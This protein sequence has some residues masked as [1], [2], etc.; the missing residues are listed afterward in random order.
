MTCKI[1]IRNYR[2][3]SLDFFQRRLI[4][5]ASNFIFLF[6]LTVEIYLNKFDDVTFYPFDIFTC[7]ND[8]DK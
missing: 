8:T 7:K 2:Y 5:S 3:S 6:Y 1:K 4:H